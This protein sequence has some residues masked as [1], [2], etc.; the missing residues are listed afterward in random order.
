M[1][2]PPPLTNKEKADLVAYLDGE[3]TGEAARAIETKLSLNPAARAEADSLRRAW[4][5]LDFLPRPEPSPSFTSRT[6][7]K[8]APLRDSKAPPSVPAKKSN[9]PWR[10]ALL[11]LGWAAAVFLASL[12]GFVGY[13]T[14]VPREPGERE[15]V[16]DLRLIENKRF[17]DVVDDLDFLRGLDQPDLFGEEPA[18][19]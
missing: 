19:W 3:L 15:L 14:A 9:R 1:S 5:M 2:Q 18:G 7:S 17:Y 16:R 13:N 10:A 8:L 11:G 6:L 4:D 12:G